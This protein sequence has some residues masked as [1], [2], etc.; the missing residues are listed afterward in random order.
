[1]LVSLTKIKKGD[2]FSFSKYVQKKVGI[3]GPLKV[4]VWYTADEILIREESLGK[5]YLVQCL[6]TGVLLKD[7]KTGALVKDIKT[8]QVWKFPQKVLA[9][10]S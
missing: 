7:V 1:M 4:S 6:K 5:G 2:R 3:H 9:V 8:G 10:A